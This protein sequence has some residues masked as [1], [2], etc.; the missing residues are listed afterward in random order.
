MF[1][2]TAVINCDVNFRYAVVAAAVAR[3]EVSKHSFESRFT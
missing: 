2:R 3:V 1:A